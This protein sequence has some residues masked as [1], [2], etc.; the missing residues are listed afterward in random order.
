MKVGGGSEELDQGR[1][2][3]SSVLTETLF[4]T[5]DKLRRYDS[6]DPSW[7]DTVS[8]YLR[9]GRSQVGGKHPR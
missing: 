9:I 8:L 1:F 6:G 2:A 4:P 5:W 7:G 3:E